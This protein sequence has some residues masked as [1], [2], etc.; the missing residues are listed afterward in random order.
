MVEITPVGTLSYPNFFKPKPKIAGS[1]ELVYS[2]SLL[3]TP[4]QAKSSKFK[5]LRDA[6]EAI[7]KTAFPKGILGKSIRS[8]FLD[9]EKF[10]K[11]PDE[12]SLVIRSWSNEKPGVVNAEKED[13]LDAAEVWPGQWAR[14]SVA[15]FAYEQAGNK[16][17]SFYLHNVQI[18]RSAGLKR[19]DGRKAA[20]ETFDD[21]YAGADEEI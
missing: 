20:A 2:G 18:V 8:P 15:P 12:Y 16:G 14:F 3:F 19:L 17:V 1:P 7:A 4:D 21:E 6:V 11:V 10:E 5:E 13:I 9:A